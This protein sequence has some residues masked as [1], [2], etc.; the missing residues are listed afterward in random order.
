[1]KLAV[2]GSG[3]VG[4]VA[5]ACFAKFGN[6]VICVDKDHKKISMLK[7]NLLPLYEP[8]LAELV[9][10]N[11]KRGRLRF[12]T[13]LAFAIRESQFIF[14]AVG[15]P[16]T[17][18][19]N[20]DMSQ[21]KNVAREIG[22]ILDSYRVIVIK[23]TV[24]IG[25]YKLVGDI[26]AQYNGNRWGQNFDIIN[27]P[28]FLRE[29]HAV[30]DFLQP[31]RIIIGGHSQ[32]AL[33]LVQQLYY[34]LVKEESRPILTMSNAS[35]E[36]CKYACNTF[37]ALKISFANEM[38]NLCDLW[39]AQYSQVQKG[40]GSDSRIGHQF[41]NAGIGYGGSC[42]PKDVRAISLFANSVGHPAEL[43]DTI[44][45]IN[46]EQK[47][48]FVKLIETHYQ[49]D[50]FSGLRFAIWGLSFKP[51]TD[52]MR[53]APSITI[54]REL[55]ARGAEVSANDPE[56]MEK[57][58]SILQEEI[59]YKEMYETLKEADALLLLTEWSVYHEPDFERMR[60]LLKE[61]VIF[62]G[63]NI[64]DPNVLA[65]L[66]FNSYGIGDNCL[67]TEIKTP[68]TLS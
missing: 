41:L 56:A 20:I 40:L 24:P 18:S 57:A 6:S 52:D 13:D 39:G 8:N 45:R 65:E 59:C 19:G 47:K 14:I 50:D 9:N 64:Y 11:Q 15:T 62:D 25:T 3:Y 46:E 67:K 44:N 23:S 35:A 68:Y 61:P 66:G 30:E 17:S 22:H 29:G 34:P 54:I 1:M 26:I 43:I 10:Y 42:F 16:E 55:L 38:A 2:I 31:D 60:T 28:E 12:T 58:R 48:R 53:S 37:L 5:G 33:Q 36:L 4:L 21:V 49:K 27:N 51:G 32:K 63:R 7:D